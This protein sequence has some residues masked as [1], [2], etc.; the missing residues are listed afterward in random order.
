MIEVLYRSID[1]WLVDQDSDIRASEI[2][3][4][5][6][7]LM[8]ANAKVR[9]DEFVAHLAEYA[10]IQPGSLAQVS[11]SI[12]LLFGGLHESWSG[13][14]LDF[15]LLL[16]DDDELIEERADALGAWCG[17]FLAGLGLSGEISKNRG[18][19]ED[20]RQAL[21]DLSE[22]ARIEAGGQ[23]ETL[24]KA[25]ADVSEHVRLA[26]LLIATELIGDQQKGPEEAIVH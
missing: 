18:L 25:F 13:I 5:L 9:P 10:D 24:E 21:E 3:G 22:I 14:G 12:E 26:A 4:L 16:P 23:D 6:A 11:D 2:Q 1:D 8:A 17:S 19:S 7:G 15:E 20:V